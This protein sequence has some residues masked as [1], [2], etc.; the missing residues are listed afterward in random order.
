MRT[1]ESPAARATHE[2]VSKA[3]GEA[4]CPARRGASGPAGGTCSSCAVT[5]WNGS[6]PSRTSFIRRPEV[7][8]SSGSPRSRLP[9]TLA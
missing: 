8:A 3:S 4:N 7:S 5:L 2:T 6:A 1:P 9:S